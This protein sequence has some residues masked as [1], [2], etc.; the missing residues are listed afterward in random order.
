[1]VQTITHEEIKELYPEVY[2]SFVLQ[3]SISVRLTA[4]TVSSPISVP[5]PLIFCVF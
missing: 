1:M 2:D 3:W 5:N 4:F